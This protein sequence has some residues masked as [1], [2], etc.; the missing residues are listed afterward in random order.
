[1]QTSVEYDADGMEVDYRS[2]TVDSAWSWLMPEVQT[3]ILG[4]SYQNE[5]RANM[6]AVC[7]EIG[8]KY[9]DIL[10]YAVL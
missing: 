8:M 7:Q 3:M 1:M 10:Y 2:D 9:S 5:H 6:K 4:L